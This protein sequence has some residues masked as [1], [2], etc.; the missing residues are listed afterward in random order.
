MLHNKQLQLVRRK[1]QIQMCDIY[2][3]SLCYTMPGHDMHYIILYTILYSL[4][5]T[6]HAAD[7]APMLHTRQGQNQTKRLMLARQSR[8]VFRWWHVSCYSRWRLQ[9]M[10][11]LVKR[12]HR[13]SR[14]RNKYNNGLFSVRLTITWLW[15]LYIIWEDENDSPFHPPQITALPAS[16]SIAW[17]S[18]SSTGFTVTRLE[19]T[20]ASKSGT[21]LG[22]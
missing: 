12:R 4:V 7:T 21:T 18:C 15:H 17:T 9:A 16:L 11:V 13:H 20:N 19:R 10:Q 3:L 8:C 6:D 22:N 1:T 5:C 2:H 14:A